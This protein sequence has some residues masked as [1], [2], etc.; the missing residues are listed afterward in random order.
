[1]YFFR[2]SQSPVKPA[3][4]IS[5]VWASGVGT[6]RGVVPPPGTGIIGGTMM[7]P[8]GGNGEPGGVT[9]VVGGVLVV[10]GRLDSSG[11]PRAP[12]EPGNSSA[13]SGADS[14]SGPAAKTGPAGTSDNRFPQRVLAT[15]S[16]SVITVS[17]LG[18]IIGFRDQNTLFP[19][20]Y[21]T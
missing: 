14:S 21:E 4:S 3:E 6:G 16:P 10:T 20:R 1:M 11:G 2:A 18:S 13:T 12:G 5:N 17:P 9:E 15:C 19:R 7:P 8:P